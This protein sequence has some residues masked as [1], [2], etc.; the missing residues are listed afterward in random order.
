MAH[1][2]VLLPESAHIV[3]VSGQLRA[4]GID[5]GG[6]L[7]DLKYR[8]TNS[9]ATFDF[10]VSTLRPAAGEPDP[11][12]CGALETV[13]SPDGRPVCY[14]NRAIKWNSIYTKYPHDGLIYLMNSQDLRA[15]SPTVA[16]QVQTWAVD[17]VDTYQ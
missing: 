1:Q 9:G 11:A 4:P 7:G 3:F 16:S 13:I 12:N 14:S 10:V 15:P 8:D 5:L 6:E 2:K 17:L